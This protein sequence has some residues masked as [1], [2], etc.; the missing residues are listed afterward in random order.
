MKISYLAGIVVVACLLT[1]AWPPAHATHNVLRHTEHGIHTTGYTFP[2]PQEYEL[3]LSLR[4]QFGFALGGQIQG[5]FKLTAT[6][7]DDLRAVTFKLKAEAGGGEPIVLGQVTQAPFSLI[8]N[9]DAYPHGHY[10]L[11]A[12]GQT[13]G[14]RVLA[15]NVLRLEFVSAEAGWKAAGTFVMPLLILLGVVMLAATLGPFLLERLGHKPR[16]PVFVPGQ[17]R[18]YGLLGGAICPKCRRPFGL[19]WW[20]INLVGGKFDRCPYCGRWS[21]VHRARREELAAAEAAELP[22]ATPDVPEL[23]PE[24]KLRRQIEES[25]YL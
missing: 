14:G 1:L 4:K 6:G 2:L 12:V 24:E 7:P 10:E 17:P 25:R 21:L 3:R 18:H 13:A 22:V 20:A 19:H 9:T 11:S 8:F 23:S 15:S 16:R 5:T